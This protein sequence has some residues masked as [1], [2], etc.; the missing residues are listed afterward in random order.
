M[1]LS[2]IC[3][4]LAVQ[5]GFAQPGCASCPPN[6][7]AYTLTAPPGWSLITI[8]VFHYRG[9]TEADAILDN[10]VA[11]LLQDVPSQTRLLKFNNST[12]RFSATTFHGNHWTDPD[13]T[14]SPGEGAFIYNPGREAFQVT[15]TGQCAYGGVLVPAGLSLISSP[16]CGTINFA[17]LV[18]TTVPTIG[19][20]NLAFDPREGDEVYTF[21][22]ASQSFKTHVFRNGAWDAP[23]ALG[24]DE[25]CFVRTTESR[26]I[27]YTGIV[28]Y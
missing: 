3:A 23:P 4:L 7:S 16:A 24:L 1:K 27:R 28:P 25:A 22:N 14:L 21:S 12:Q 6:H 8:R 20:D 10:R 17:P 18:F 13:E 9:L 11:E 2:V 26:W 5:C 15:V 19:W